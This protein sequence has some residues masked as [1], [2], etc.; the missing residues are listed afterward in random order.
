MYNP[1]MGTVTTLITA[2]QLF[3]MG[4]EGRNYELVRGE[5][6]HMAPVNNDHGSTV[7]DLGYLIVGFVKANRLGK[8]YTEVGFMLSTNP[9]TLRAPDIAFVAADHLPARNRKGFVKDV[10]PDLVVEVVSPSDRFADMQRKI[11]EYREAGVKLIWLVDPESETVTAYHPSGD[12]HVY[13]GDQAVPGE[14]VLPGFSFTP[15]E[16]FLFD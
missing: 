11:R 12:I 15:A 14:D 7:M 16:L 6:E 2:D 5:L 1:A 3:E 13:S 10:I 4:E 8:V 9:D